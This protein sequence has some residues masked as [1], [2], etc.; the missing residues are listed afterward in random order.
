M[1]ET[2]PRGIPRYLR[3]L[4]LGAAFLLCAGWAQAQLMG[5]GKLTIVSGPDA[6]SNYVY[7]I[8]ITNTG[9]SDIGTFWFGWMPTDNQGDGNSLLLSAPGPVSAPTGWS[10]SNS[11][12]GGNSG[13]G[14]S[15]LWVTSNNPTP[16]PILPNT[17]L[18]GFTFTTGDPCLL[19]TSRCV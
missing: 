16:N 12:G 11:G 17:T 6:D 8:S 2:P 3:Q 15:V 1:P 5:T 7:T 9:T 19:Y 18:A 14:I 10:T 13:D 4:V